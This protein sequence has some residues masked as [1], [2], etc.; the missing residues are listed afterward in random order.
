MSGFSV[1]DFFDSAKAVGG[2]RTLVGHKVRFLEKSDTQ[3]ELNFVSDLIKKVFK[4]GSHRGQ[5]LRR[6][7]GQ[8]LTSSDPGHY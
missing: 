3:I 2:N 4:E 7:H 6:N 5:F 8:K 1:S